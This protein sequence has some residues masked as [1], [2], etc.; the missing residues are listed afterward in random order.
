MVSEQKKKENYNK[1]L[2]I[3]NVSMTKHFLGLL[4]I[5][6]LL[7][8][9]ACAIKSMQHRHNTHKNGIESNGIEMVML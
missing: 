4:S 2:Y 1:P 3:G 7:D 8:D 9:D 5:N 6:K